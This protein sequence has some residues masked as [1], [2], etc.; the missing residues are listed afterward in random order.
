MQQE[1]DSEGLSSPYRDVTEAWEN[2]LTSPSVTDQS[3]RRSPR[4]TPWIIDHDGISH[5]SVKYSVHWVD[6]MD[7]DIMSNLKHY[8]VRLRVHQRDSPCQATAD[9][10]KLRATL[11]HETGVEVS[12]SFD[13]GEEVPHLNGATEAVVK[14]GEAVFNL[15]LGSHIRSTSYPVSPLFCLRFEPADEQFRGL[16][17]SLVALSSPFCVK[18]KPNPIKDRKAVDER[19]LERTLDREFRP[20]NSGQASTQPIECEA[21]R[22]LAIT[23]H[24]PHTVH[25]QEMVITPL[26][27]FR[28]EIC[29]HDEAGTVVRDHPDL[30]LVAQLV[31][32]DQAPVDIRSGK[33]AAALEGER[34]IL[35]HGR[36]IFSIKVHE[37][38]DK[39]ERARFCIKIT[40]NDDPMPVV[41]TQPVA[42]SK[43]MRSITKLPRLKRQ[44]VVHEELPRSI[45][46]PVSQS[47]ANASFSSRNACS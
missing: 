10:L 4:L 35:T 45:G 26:K 44:R 42:L 12:A 1:C 43:P 40:C 7:Q 3:P 27:A 17:Q 47:A 5:F 30:K 23:N 29:L 21:P 15:K 39:H 33:K 22:H 11:R 13:D 14:D 16:H 18:T 32:E 24:W 6:D 41:L 2:L 36:A 31:D 20:L 38:S 8:R 28:L 25:D 34:A 37:L 19:E 46:Q 9:G